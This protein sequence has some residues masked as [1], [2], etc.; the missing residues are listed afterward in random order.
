MFVEIYGML[1]YVNVEQMEKKIDHMLDIY[2]ASESNN[3]KVNDY[4][5]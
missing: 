2:K 4:L 5:N 3:K 1:S